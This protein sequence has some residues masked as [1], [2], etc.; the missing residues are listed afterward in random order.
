[1]WTNLVIYL[2]SC[3][4]VIFSSNSFTQAYILEMGQAMHLEIPL[5]C[6]CTEEQHALASEYI[7]LKIM[8]SQLFYHSRNVKSQ[9]ELSTHPFILLKKIGVC[10]GT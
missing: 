4:S 5:G 8:A 9:K 2:S 10:T 1:M 3:T 6:L 7:T